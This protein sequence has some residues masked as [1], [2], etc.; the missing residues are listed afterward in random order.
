MMWRLSGRCAA[1]V[2]A[3]AAAL[4]AGA[5]EY[6]SRTVRIVSPS[7]PGG[8]TDLIARLVGDRLATSL[9]VPV[10]VENRPGGTGAVA[11]DFVAKAP[12]DGYTLVVGFS[13]A[14]VIHPLM[15]PKLSFNA[16]RD[17]TAVSMVFTGANVLVVHP[18]V[19]VNSYREFVTYVRS[20]PKP[21]SYGSWGPG[22]GGHLA[23]EY[24]KMLTGIDMVHVPY[25]STTALTTDVVG[26]HMPLAFL[27]SFNAIT[28][29]RS[30]KVRALAQ[31]GPKRSPM[32]PNV[33]TLQEEGVSFSIGAWIGFF[34]PAGLPRAILARLNSE[35][36]Q[37]LAAP[38]LADRWLNI[39]G[40]APTPMKPEEF[41]RVIA[42]D[43]EIWKKVIAEAKIKP[44]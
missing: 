43:W 9:K 5:Q 6:P 17:F 34:G 19:P 2:V 24:L 36:N 30:G 18:A 40:Y 42:Q 10:I 25:K 20:Q 38:D 16:Q 8:I 22:S 13:G 29:S 26:G 1:L 21:P 15:N 31:A 3:L 28:Q 12:A 33:P 32:L 39:S 44:E 11:L 41:E 35:I 27:D 37:V 7:A 23:G 14:N 4:P